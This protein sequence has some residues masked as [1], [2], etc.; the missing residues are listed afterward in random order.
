MVEIQDLNTQPTITMNA[1]SFTDVTVIIVTYNSA[2]CLPGLAPL[3]LQCPHVIISDNASLDDTIS[4][5]QK[6]IPHAQLLTHSQNMGFGAANNRALAQT[7]TPLALLLNP[8]CE[9]SPESLQSLLNQADQF[10]D[11]G[12]L[13]PQLYNADQKIEINY[14]WPSIQWSGRG[15]GASGPACVGF[16][17]G[18]V[19]LLKLKHFQQTGFF[20]ERFFLYYEDD[21][22]CLR[23][24]QAQ[25]PMMICPEIHAIHRSRGSVRGGSVLKNEYIR[26]YH[27]AQSKLLYVQ[28]HQSENA[29]LHL[30]W[31][32]LATT[33]LALPLRIM[34]F[35]PRLI[36]RMMGRFMGL[37][38]YKI[39]FKTESK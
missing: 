29:A 7:Q 36:A 38:R 32:V 1:H 30:R 39:P 4:I 2:H 12:I 33:I 37:I 9:I 5:S 26:G 31:K 21:D 24:F 15:P 6:L 17:T 16:I 14:R 11:A 3:L 27:H 10:A 19:M 13:A 34:V 28:I 18:A 20:D 23:L 25:V 8:D 35:S 22:L